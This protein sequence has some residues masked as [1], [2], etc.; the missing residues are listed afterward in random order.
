MHIWNI[1]D[2]SQLGRM[3]TQGR[4]RGGYQ[5]DW[6][7]TEDRVAHKEQPVCPEQTPRQP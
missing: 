6:Q 7:E 1:D 3:F 5:S 4:D 2:A